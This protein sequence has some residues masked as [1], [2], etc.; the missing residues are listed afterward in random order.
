M[1]LARFWSASCQLLDCQACLLLIFLWRQRQYTGHTDSLRL[2]VAF[3]VSTCTTYTGRVTFRPPHRSFHLQQP[4]LIVLLPSFLIVPI[5][6]QLDSLYVE[7]S[8]NN[9]SQAWQIESIYRKQIKVACEELVTRIVVR[10]E[11]HTQALADYIWS[12][13]ANY[14]KYPN[15][16]KLIL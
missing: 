10:N 16:E 7:G 15:L 3:V 12:A 8:V 13:M 9:H 14:E 11:E 2:G 5:L 4:P 1:I 6:N